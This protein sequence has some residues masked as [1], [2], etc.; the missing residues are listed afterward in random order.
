MKIIA[1]L[2]CFLQYYH[3][4]LNALGLGDAG[5]LIK[6]GGAASALNPSQLSGVGSDPCKAFKTLGGLQSSGKA[7]NG[8]QALISGNT[9]GGLQN[10]IQAAQAKQQADQNMYKCQQLISALNGGG[11]S[12]NTANLGGNG[13]P[14]L[15]GGIPNLGGG[16]GVPNPV[17]GGLMSSLG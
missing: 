5:G 9:Q 14:N 3:N 6:L 11:G 4:A 1:C 12:L 13:M 17:D 10:L 8:A 16:G 7:G 15:G 2:L